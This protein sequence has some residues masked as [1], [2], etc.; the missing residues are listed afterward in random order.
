M[1]IGPE[2]HNRHVWTLSLTEP[3]VQFHVTPDVAWWL[4]LLFQTWE[5]PDT[6]S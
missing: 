4:A 6:K 1:L 5:L 3:H 2:L